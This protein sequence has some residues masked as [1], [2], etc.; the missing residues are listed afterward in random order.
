ML[1]Q[2]LAD[3]IAFQSAHSLLDSL[4]GQVGVQAD[5]GGAR[6]AYQHPV[7]DFLSAEHAV[8]AKGL[9]VPDEDA[10]PAQHLFEV[11]GKGS[12]D[13]PFPAVDRRYRHPILFTE[14]LTTLVQIPTGAVYDAVYQV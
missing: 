2:R 11:I 6:V 12:M 8:R 13:R 9:L 10:V 4:I 5:E 7:V 3:A 1:H 14:L